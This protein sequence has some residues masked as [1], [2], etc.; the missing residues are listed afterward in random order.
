MDRNRLM[1]FQPG[2]QPM[3]RN[4]VADWLHGN[5]LQGMAARFND[6][7]SGA[8]LIADA[9][10]GFGNMIAAPVHGFNRLMDRGYQA[11]TGDQQGVEDAFDV[12]GGAMVGGL[13]AP[14]AGNSVRART[15]D[16]MIFDPPAKP[17]RPFDADYGPNNPAR[18]DDAG[19][20]THDIEG[21]PITAAHVAGRRT[22]GGADE[23]ITPAQYD[24]IATAAT[25]RVAQ[26]LPASQMG[27]DLGRA[28][29][30]RETGEPVDIFLRDDLSPKSRERV[31]AHE[32]GHYSNTWAMDGNSI[33]VNGLLSAELG[34]IF[35]TLNNPNR[36]RPGAA[37]AGDAAPWSKSVRPEHMGYK[38][39]DIPHEYMAEAIRAYM[40]DPNYLKTVA[41]GTAARIRAAVNSHPELSKIVQFN[42]G[43]VPVPYRDDDR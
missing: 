18:S 14:R 8:G 23:A 16:A 21:R 33:P 28:I 1:E 4:R 9:V 12:A 15:K 10:G 22:V 38:G 34:P 32:L 13:L 25:G 42:V 24:A 11:G 20:L 37:N 36:A 3:P 35:N 7:T 31:Y 17:Q 6:P 30:Q 2:P 39:D 41:P 43:G 40:T 5:G 29:S 19:R 26:E 27:R